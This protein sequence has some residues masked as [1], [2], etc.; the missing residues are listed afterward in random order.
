MKL[1]LFV[2]ARLTSKRFPKKIFS[3]ID[4]KTLIEILITKLKKVKKVNKII[5]VIPNNKKNNELA[6][7]LRKLK[8]TIFRG[9]E[10][11]VL[12]RFYKAALK[13][14]VENI[15]RITADCPLID[16]K[17]I[18]QIVKK[19][20]NGNYDY[21]TNTLPPTFPDGL[22]VEVFSF[23]SLENAWLNGK[24]LHQKEHV[25]P[26]LR[27]KKKFR[28]INILNNTN[29]KK[30]RLTIDWKEDLILIEK[31]F[32]FFKPKINFY[33]KD[34]N[35]IIKKHPEWFKINSKYRVR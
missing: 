20:F 31:I 35:K 32:N 3:K 19:Y 33:L 16:T 4:N 24:S 15:V 8:I 9:N 7:N 18:D 25:T 30:I 22:D 34:I 5:V 21:A 13:F 10:N 17:L 26:F 23:T 6:F 28:I 11:N 27:N 29:Q 1:A 12:D 14:N 2:Q